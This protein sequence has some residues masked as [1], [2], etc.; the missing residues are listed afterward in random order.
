M[1]EFTDAEMQQVPCLTCGAKSGQK[2]EEK[3]DGNIVIPLIGYHKE[4]VQLREKLPVIPTDMPV[5]D[6]TDKAIIIYYAFVALCNSCQ[7]KSIEL[8]GKEFTSREIQFAFATQ[9]LKAAQQDGLIGGP[10]PNR[11]ERRAK[12]V[13]KSRIIM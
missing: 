8:F 11:K 7:T 13:E 1:N 5:L 3:V 12:A 2:C 4:R 9:G 6:S 10:K